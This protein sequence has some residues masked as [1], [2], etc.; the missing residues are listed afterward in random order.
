M[1]NNSSG[2]KNIF[3]LLDDDLIKN[4]SKLVSPHLVSSIIVLSEDLE[5][6]FLLI[7]FFAHLL[8]LLSLLAGLPFL[9]LFLAVVDNIYLH[10]PSDLSGNN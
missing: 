9:L 1:T 7:L 3:V 2:N 6:D 10:S 5:T 8:L 4:T